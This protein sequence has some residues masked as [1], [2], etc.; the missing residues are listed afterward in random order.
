MSKRKPKPKPKF[1]LKITKA[2][3]KTIREVSGVVFLLGFG[4]YLLLATLSEQTSASANSASETSTAI[5]SASES[6][7]YSPN[8]RILYKSDIGDY[9][10]DDPRH[11]HA[12]TRA[13]DTTYTYD[14]NGNRITE[15]RNN[16]TTT[17][18]YNAFNH[19]VSIINKNGT[20]KYVYSHN[21]RVKKILPSAQGGQ[22]GKSITYTNNDLAEI[23]DTSGSYVTYLFLEQQRI[24]TIFNN[25]IRYHVNDHLNS[26]SLMLDQYGGVVQ[27]RD[28]L[29]FGQERVNIMNDPYMSDIPLHSFTDK[30]QDPESGL[31][32]FKARYYD[33]RIGVFTQQDPVIVRADMNNPAFQYALLNPQLLNPYAYVGNNPV[34]NVDEE[35]EFALPAV[36]L[37]GGAGYFL[38]TWG[39]SIAQY[40]PA[41]ID[42]PAFTA[43]VVFRMAPVTGDAT[44]FAEGLTGLDIFTGE[45]LSAAD[46]TLTRF[47]LML[48]VIPGKGARLLKNEAA[49]R[50]A[51]AI[52]DY[53]IG[54]IIKQVEKGVGDFQ[55]PV[56]SREQAI[57]AGMKFVGENPIRTLNREGIPNGWRNADSTRVFR[58]PEPKDYLNG[59][60]VANLEINVFNQRANKMENI[61]NAHL[62]WN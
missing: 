53:K 5:A 25:Q 6:Y 52:S 12:P 27:K 9:E 39:P 16:E 54:G 51:R 46:L 41:F 11:P 14:A 17:Y 22:D 29:P 56:A 4:F 24:A 47:S 8:G 58:G 59:R 61:S 32:Y 31:I 48:P 62:I 13:G 33:P 44:D 2:K 15:T 3:R 50:A 7:R 36:A 49:Q 28:Y 60:E 40:V 23:D 30:E 42:E 10:Y 20:T 57:A 1:R 18:S 21:R 43:E 19:L 37:G 26:P 34:K 55:I 35:G 45:Q 38:A